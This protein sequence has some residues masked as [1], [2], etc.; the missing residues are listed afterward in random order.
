[1]LCPEHQP[2]E[3]VYYG[4]LRTELSPDISLCI[5]TTYW[6][7]SWLERAATELSER[8]LSMHNFS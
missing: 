4:S 3:V 6:L 8:V 5:E 7:L 2:Q 1:M